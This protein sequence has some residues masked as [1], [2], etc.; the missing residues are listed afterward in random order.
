MSVSP[1]TRLKI[2]LPEIVPLGLVLSIKAVLANHGIIGGL[3]IGIYQNDP[4][5]LD[6]IEHN[7]TPDL[8]QKVY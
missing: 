2:N 8:F 3:S 6:S 7:V 1:S 4:Y 5:Y